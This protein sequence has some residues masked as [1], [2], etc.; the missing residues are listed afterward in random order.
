MDTHVDQGSPLRVPGDEFPSIKSRIVT[1][2]RIGPDGTR[3][4][5]T[6]GG[7]KYLLNHE[8]EKATYMAV[9][10]GQ[11]SSDVFH[12]ASAI[13]ERWVKEIG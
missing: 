10:T 5:T 8:P 7:K 12:V 9:L 6:V 11:W 13:R 4:A 3:F 2:I 1:L